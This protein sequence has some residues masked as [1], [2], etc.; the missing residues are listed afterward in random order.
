MARGEDTSRH[1]NRRPKIIDLNH[2]RQ[3]GEVK[4]VRELNLQQRTEAVTEGNSRIN[5]PTNRSRKVYDYVEEEKK[6]SERENKVS[7][8]TDPTP[9]KG[10]PRPEAAKDY[11][12]EADFIDRNPANKTMIEKMYDKFEKHVND[13]KNQRD[14]NKNKDE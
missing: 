3:T 10:T 6:A 11:P 5:H 14:F 1:G 13:W 2:F 4:D 12:E 9:Y 8:D 7:E